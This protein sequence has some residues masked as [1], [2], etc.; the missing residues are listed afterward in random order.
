M[1]SIVS[2]SQGWRTFILLQFQPQYLCIILMGIFV[3][4]HYVLMDFAF[5]VAFKDKVALQQAQS[6][7][8]KNKFNSI[9][10]DLVTS[11]L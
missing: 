2:S 6:V 1:Y 3:T 9:Q 5:A 8:K 11:F 10:N 7:S 4:A